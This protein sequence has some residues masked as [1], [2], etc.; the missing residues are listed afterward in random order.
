M[1]DS[2]GCLPFDLSQQQFV[3]LVHRVGQSGGPG[4]G[5]LLDGNIAADRSSSRVP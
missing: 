3:Q 2:A 4:S 1:G 5:Q